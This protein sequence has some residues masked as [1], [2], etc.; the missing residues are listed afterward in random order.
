[1]NQQELFKLH[2]TTCAKA[3]ETMRSKNHDYSGGGDPFS[4]FRGSEILGIHPV[5]GILLRMQDKIKRINTF[6]TK[7]KLEVKN[8][9]VNDAIEDIINY[10]ILIK[11]MLNDNKENPVDKEAIERLQRIGY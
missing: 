10:A 8:E 4:N 3:L 7:G 11:G 5:V 9:G 6:A 2:E 1:M